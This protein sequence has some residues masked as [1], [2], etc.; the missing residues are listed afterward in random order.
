M[1]I[2]NQL[3]PRQ[4]YASRATTLWLLAALA[5]AFAPHML[6]LPLTLTAMCLLFG[7]WRLMIERRATALPHKLIKALLLL[8]SLVLVYLHYGTLLGREAGIALLAVMLSLKLLEMRTNRD[9]VVVILLGYFLAITLVLYNQTLPMAV[10]MI[11]VALMLTT[12]LIDLNM[13]QQRRRVTTNLRLTKKL[14]LQALPIML[15]M[16]F[17][18]PRIPGPLWSLP[19]DAHSGTTG[20]NDEMSMGSISNLSQSDKIAFRVEFEDQV[21]DSNLNYWRGPVLWHT[22]GKQWRVGEQLTRRSMVGYHS[23]DKPVRYTVTLEPHN[24]KW[25]YGLDLPAMAPEGSMVSDDY[26]LLTSAKVQKLQRYTLT[27]YSEYNT[28]PLTADELRRALQ[29]P[30]GRNREALALGRKWATQFND[31]E[32]IVAQAL[33]YFNQQPFR[34]TLQ[35]PLLGNN[36]VD[37]FLFNTLAGFCEHYSASFT[38]LM[39]AAGIPA[40]IVT[41]YQGG[42]FNPVG[43]Y[44]IVRQR[45]AHAWAEVWIEDKGWVRVDPT[46]AVA[47]ERVELGAEQAFSELFD[48]KSTFQFKNNFLA[49]QWLKMRYGWDAL[50]NGWNQWVIGY[51]SIKQRQ[52]LSS[53]GFE[54]VR[55]KEMAIVMMITI[56]VTLF[57]LLAITLYRG[58]RQQDAITTAYQHFCK[59]ITAIGIKREP[60]EGP[61]DFA[62]RI[63]AQRPDLEPQVAQINELYIALKYRPR[64]TQ[65]QVRQLQQQV[66]SLKL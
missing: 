31:P 49:N 34:Y 65:Q 62:Q 58:K 1:T 46:A 25:L 45:D 36:P 14:F 50:N 54:S 15:I 43:N 7:L 51:S 4:I 52:L 40:R 61:V 59:K 28:G 53:L 30:P 41:G 39:R 2:E 60:Y 42:D 22:D 47:P 27:S 5:L 44:L 57:A 35:P 29:L 64:H 8:V 38:T 12:T 17:L 3:V 6:R 24:Q 13:P 19:D 33:A 16:F 66:R 21:I 23:A 55:G 63:V 37:E 26:R 11:T 20:I 9:Y 18:F 32:A 10:Y 48:R 56:I